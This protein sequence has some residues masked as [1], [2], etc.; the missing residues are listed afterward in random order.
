[1]PMQN[2]MRPPY[3]YGAIEAA[4][5]QAPNQLSIAFQNWLKAQRK[6]TMPQLRALKDAGSMVNEFTQ[7]PITAGKRALGAYFQT[8]NQY[9]Q[10]SMRTLE[11]LGRMY[12]PNMTNPMKNTRLGQ[13]ISRFGSSASTAIPLTGEA[14]R[15]ARTLAGEGYGAAFRGARQLYQGMNKRKSTAKVSKRSQV[16]KAAPP[17]P[18]PIKS[19][20]REVS[21][22]LG[23]PPAQAMQTTKQIYQEYLNSHYNR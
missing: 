20:A 19:L 14:L 17:M 7:V 10:P 3:G 4:K 15:A 1:M 11:E 8:A 16:R 22:K 12:V 9:G 21:K 13:S 2:M 6:A 18:M 5:A 23:I